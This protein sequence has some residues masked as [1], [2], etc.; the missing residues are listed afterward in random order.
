MSEPARSLRR[1]HMAARAGRHAH[2]IAP[3]NGPMLNM[4]LSAEGTTRA[5]SVHHVN[6]GL[7]APRCRTHPAHRAH[8]PLSVERS[9]KSTTSWVLASC[10]NRI[11]SAWSGF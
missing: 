5:T 1:K 8:P 2:G 4:A 11:S 9:A 10:L 6:C 7:Y 3:S